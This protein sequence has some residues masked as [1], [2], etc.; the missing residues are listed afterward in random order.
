MKAKKI[1]GVVL[2]LSVLAV[3]LSTVALTTTNKEIIEINISNK[4]VHTSEYTFDL[5]KGPDDGQTD[6]P[7]QG[8]TDKGP[9]DGQTDTPLQGI[10]DKGPDDGQTDTPLQG[11]GN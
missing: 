9:D 3:V 2:V 4:G 6:T 11:L 5:I 1:F 7:L 10:T 8:I